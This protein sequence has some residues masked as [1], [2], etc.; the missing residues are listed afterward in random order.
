[1]PRGS[2][3]SA[4]CLLESG[5]LPSDSDVVKVILGCGAVARLCFCA[6]L[7][8]LARKPEDQLLLLSCQHMFFCP[9]SGQSRAGQAEELLQRE[10]RSGR[11]DLG[12]LPAADV[13]H[14]LF[15]LVWDISDPTVKA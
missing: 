14:I 15:S 8:L 11:E 13:N 1:M 9:G 2:T 12:R 6:H 3:F 5:V 7:F 10:E 4:L